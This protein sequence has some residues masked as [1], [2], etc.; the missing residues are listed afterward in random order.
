M[1]KNSLKNIIKNV[2][3]R[4]ISI[5]PPNLFAFSHIPKKWDFLQFT[6]V[7]TENVTLTFHMISY[8]KGNLVFSTISVCYISKTK[9]DPS[10]L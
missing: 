7:K 4:P 5:A 10:S 1:S 2:F 3:T 6:L 9:L 8:P